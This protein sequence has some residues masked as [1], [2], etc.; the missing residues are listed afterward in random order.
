MR[1]TVRS[2]KY[3]MVRVTANLRTGIF[4]KENLSTVSYMV[5]ANSNGPTALC[6]RVNSE[7]MKSLVSVTT[8]GWMDLLTRDLFLMALDTE[9]E[10][11][12]TRKKELSTMV[13]GNRACVMDREI[14]NTK[15]T[16]SIQDP[17]NVV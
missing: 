11:T 7:R 16:L 17:G 8:S 3:T 4:S 13:T 2:A 15:T 5:E 14:L 6:T 1:R 12:T 10:S 9:K